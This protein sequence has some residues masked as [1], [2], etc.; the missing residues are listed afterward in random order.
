M[1]CAGTEIQGSTPIE[2]LFISQT[3]PVHMMHTAPNSPRNFKWPR[4]HTTPWDCEKIR[5]SQTVHAQ[6]VTFDPL[7]SR[8][9]QLCNESA[10][11]QYQ[12][13]TKAPQSSSRIQPV[14]TFR[15][16][17]LPHEHGFLFKS[18]QHLRL[19]G[20]PAAPATQQDASNDFFQGD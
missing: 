16:K 13:H 6:L 14:L 3:R 18:N 19:V 20:L 2:P 10:E 1:S 5:T 9:E 4:H 11:K 7:A 17:T 15:G 8:V 12:C